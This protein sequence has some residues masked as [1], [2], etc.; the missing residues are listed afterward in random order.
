MKKN[1]T[2]TNKP[3]TITIEGVKLNNIN[4]MIGDFLRRTLKLQANAPEGIYYVFEFSG[5]FDGVTF[6]KYKKIDEKFES[7]VFD[8]GMIGDEYFNFNPMSNIEKLIAIEEQK[9]MEGT[10]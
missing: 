5:C 7:E 3:A 4:E 8:Y 10:I 6:A 2:T 1:S 9:Q